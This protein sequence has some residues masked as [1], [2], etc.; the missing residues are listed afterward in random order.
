MYCIRE[1]YVAR[2]ENDPC[3]QVGTK[4]ECQNEVYQY[5]SRLPYIIDRIVDVGTG[6][7]FKLMKYFHDSITLGLDIEPNLSL[8]RELYPEVGWK[9]RSWAL[10]DWDVPR[11]GYDLMIVADVI[12]HLPDPDRLMEFIRRSAPTFLIIST[13]DRDAL[14]REFEAGPPRN[15]THVREWSSAEFRRYVEGWFAVMD[16]VLPRDRK[17]TSTQFILARG[18]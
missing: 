3:P 11:T 17:I 7:G 8:V 6:S 14:P 1:D 12:E 10:S 5:A 4:D 9:S 13:P 16:H 2:P 18:K 15:S